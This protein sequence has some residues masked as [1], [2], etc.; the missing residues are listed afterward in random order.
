MMV[1]D[2]SKGRGPQMHMLREHK[3]A[4]I[5]PWLIN[6]W[7]GARPPTLGHNSQQVSEP[8]VLGTVTINGGG[9]GREDAYSWKL[10]KHKLVYGALGTKGFRECKAKQCFQVTTEVIC[11][12]RLGT[13]CSQNTDT[14][15]TM[16]LL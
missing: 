4:I 9:G 11:G 10:H 8:G 6:G 16:C 12:K 2:A 7:D 14:H 1:N 5:Q 13:L 15:V 3:H